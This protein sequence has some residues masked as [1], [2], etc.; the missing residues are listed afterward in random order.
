MGSK[1]SKPDET[2]D[3]APSGACPVKHSNKAPDATGCPV[4]HQQYNVY[5]QPIDP[6]NQ[7]PAVANHLPSPFQTTDLLTE[8]IQSNIPK[9][10]AD[11]GTMWMYPSPQM[12]YNALTRKQ[13]LGT[14]EELDVESVM[15]L[16]CMILM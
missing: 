13:K 12:F 10:G 7:M 4:K 8:R 9:G 1:S 5:S 2:K 3:T 6:K 11:E 16:Q 15:A 14:T